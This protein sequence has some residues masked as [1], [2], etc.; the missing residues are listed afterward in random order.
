[1]KRIMDDTEEIRFFLESSKY[2]ARER[3]VYVARN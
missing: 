1:M 3:D 2:V